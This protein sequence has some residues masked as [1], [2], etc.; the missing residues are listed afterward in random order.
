MDVVVVMVILIRCCFLLCMC[1]VGVIN[2]M[3]L[4]VWL[5]SWNIGM[6]MF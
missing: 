6:F 1:V 5:G 2:V 4:S 3:E